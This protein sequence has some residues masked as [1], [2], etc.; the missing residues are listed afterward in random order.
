MENLISLNYRSDLNRE[1]LLEMGTFPQRFN[2][3]YILRR[4][5]S[6]IDEVSSEDGGVK[7]DFCFSNFRIHGRA[8][9]P[10]RYRKSL[11]TGLVFPSDGIVKYQVKFGDFFFNQGRDPIMIDS[12][13]E[14][15]SK[16]KGNVGEEFWREYDVANWLLFSQNPLRNQK[17]YREFKSILPLEIIPSFKNPQS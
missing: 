9:L 4:L 8:V 12:S 1:D 7:L 6:Y 15:D 17:V 3:K 14:V 2:P 5:E 11:R 10:R 16:A 13:F